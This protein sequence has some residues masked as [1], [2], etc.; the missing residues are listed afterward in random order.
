M[1]GGLDSASTQLSFH[2]KEASNTIVPAQGENTLQHG[3]LYQ[4][5]LLL[6]KSERMPLTLS[7]SPSSG[8]SI[9]LIS[10]HRTPAGV[11]CACGDQRPCSAAVY[12]FKLRVCL[13]YKSCCTN[14]I[15]RHRDACHI[16]FFF[17]LKNAQT[18]TRWLCL[19]V[20]APWWP[21]Q[22]YA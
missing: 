14:N 12:R 7:S 16:P 2:H 6:G 10:V 13:A 19:P 15:R 22:S 17:S 18:Q 9:R 4:P 3:R 20:P 11:C 21:G 5:V 8:V 1:Q